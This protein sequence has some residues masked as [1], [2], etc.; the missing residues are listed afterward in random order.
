MADDHLSR[1]GGGR[2]KPLGRGLAALLGEA[3]AAPGSH[4]GMVAV[5]VSRLMPSAVQPRRHFDEEAL[6]ELAESI[7]AHGVIQPLVVRA[8]PGQTGQPRAAQ[9]EI[10]AGERRWRAAQRAGLDQ[11]PVLVRDISDRE[12]LGLALVENLQRADLSPIEEADAY[13]RLM[14]DFGLTQDSVASLV[15]RSRPQVSNTL[16]LL[17]LPPPVREMV[18]DGRLS[19]G[20]A[21]AL[22]NTP[23][24]EA[25]ADRVVA[26]G[27]TVREAERLAQAGMM[28]APPKVEDR[29]LRDPNVVAL[30]N[31]L[32][33][34]LGLK[35]SLKVK[36][37]AHGSL[38]LHYRSLEQLDGLLAL[39][40]GRMN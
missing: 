34:A 2:G 11:V 21:R 10:V 23:D 12:A 1:P 14:E 37:Q 26:E 6:A 5:P 35:A 8:R 3:S 32:S 38:T 33:A 7:K 25:L 29:A 28:S 17:R 20:H 40:H 39:L 36:D 16:R 27:L 4:A 13:R 24:P 19:A 15:G 9:Y 18:S 31:E 22:V 30:E